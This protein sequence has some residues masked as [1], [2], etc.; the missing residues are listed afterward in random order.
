VTAR[1]R[2]QGSPCERRTVSRVDARPWQ[3]S[4]RSCDSL[5][6]DALP[7]VLAVLTAVL[8]V[9]VSF[10][11]QADD[12]T[13]LPPPP[14]AALTA[15]DETLIR[16]EVDENPALSARYI[17]CRRL[18]VEE[19]SAAL[20]EHCFTKLAEE[21]GADAALATD[22][23]ALAHD[24]DAR[25]RATRATAKD[26]RTLL[27][28]RLILSGAPEG[29]IGGALSG[30]I[31]GFLATA[32]VQS[33][34]RTDMAYGT[35]WLIG[36]PAA[37]LLAGGALGLGLGFVAEPGD[38]SLVS[39]SSLIGIATGLALQSVL[40]WR[41]DLVSEIPLRYAMPLAT[42]LAFTL[43]SSG[44]APFIDV[45]PGDAALA[46]SAAVWAPVFVTMLSL[47]AIGLSFDVGQPINVFS[48]D[49]SI[50]V[51]VLLASSLGAWLATL[52]LHPFVDVPRPATWLVEGGIAAGAIAFTALL[53]IL[54]LV[55]WAFRVVV[56]YTLIPVGYTLSMAA[57]AGLG[58]TLAL[59]SSRLVPELSVIGDLLERSPLALAP[60]I[61][62]D[63]LAP[64][65]V[66]VSLALSGNL[67]W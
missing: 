54:S 34:L 32:V 19:Q 29:L 30:A 67:P 45:T 26:N 38:A 15:T 5:R 8:A 55:P 66:T 37:S 10:S 65:R 17:A 36:V 59:L 43:V 28:E 25:D 46:V 6:G 52:A 12:D 11:A 7:R 20:A 57:G 33:V 22:M 16:D 62:P 31:Y 53:P 41:A 18:L 27:G 1:A 58:L 2:T 56:P 47:S 40:F 4:R 50:P 44:A 9:A 39:S 64:S 63:P 49:A 3:C 13:T 35:P 48:V 60:V 42:G 21:G 61:A 14:P 23:A 51:G 24:L